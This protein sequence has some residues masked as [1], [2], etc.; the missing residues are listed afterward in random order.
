MDPTH[1]DRGF[2][3]RTALHSHLRIRTIAPR[4]S[5]SM[6]APDFPSRCL[7]TA[8]ACIAQ[9]RTHG[10]RVSSSV[11]PG[12]FG[13]GSDARLEPEV[14]EAVQVDLLAA[15]TDADVCTMQERVSAAQDSARALFRATFM[16][17]PRAYFEG[18]RT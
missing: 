6:D 13:Q 9:L 5:C 12:V 10:D 1:W 18:L 11:T 14:V 15:T 17:W 7:C 2:A 8:Q 3:R 4:E 16:G